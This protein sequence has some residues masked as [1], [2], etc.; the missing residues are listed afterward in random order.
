M[1]KSNENLRQCLRTSLNIALFVFC[2]DQLAKLC[3]V[4]YFQSAGHGSITIIPGFFSLNYT[5]NKGAAF[6]I[7]QSRTS[8]LTFLGILMLIVMLLGYRK[9][10]LELK[11]SRFAFGCLFGGILGNTLDR[12]RLGYVIDFLD[13]HVRHWHWPSFNIADSAIVLAC[14]FYCF[15][16]LFKN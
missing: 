8:L 13:F 5:T 16:A 14:T 9:C 15:A 7:L 12:I 11:W 2:L 3:I 10:E 6:G 4:H 1:K